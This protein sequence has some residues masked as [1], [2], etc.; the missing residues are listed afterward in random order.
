MNSQPGPVAIHW[1]R[2]FDDHK[3]TLDDQDERK[4]EAVDAC[5]CNAADWQGDNP[6]AEDLGHDLP[7]DGVDPICEADTEHATNSCMGR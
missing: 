5:R 6:R 3:S 7:I 1:K 4:E 2:C